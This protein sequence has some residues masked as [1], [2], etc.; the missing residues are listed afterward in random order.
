MSG[1][2]APFLYAAAII[3]MMVAVGLIVALISGN[4][5]KIPQGPVQWMGSVIAVLVVLSGVWLIILASEDDTVPAPTRGAIAS[6]DQIEDM[7]ISTPADDFSFKLV[8]AGTTSRLSDYKGKVI[9]LNIWATWCPPCLYEIPD[10]NRIHSDYADSGVVVLSLS[11]EGADELKEF[12]ESTPLT[13]ISGYVEDPGSLPKLIRS[14]FDIRPT[15]FVI[16][17]EG[18]IRKYVLGA[19]NYRYFQRTVS[20][21]L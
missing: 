17:R 15:S 18:I 12:A 2:G 14:G 13:T 11:D 10:L 20:E 3:M 16:D 8:A 7:D 1:V 6:P 4:E 5:R 9:L 21:H 19:R